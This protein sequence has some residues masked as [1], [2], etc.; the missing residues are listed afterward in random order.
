ME[1]VNILETMTSA[2]KLYK[3]ILG[4]LEIQYH[5]N[6]QNV[7]QEE[8]LMRIDKIDQVMANLIKIANTIEEYHFGKIENINMVYRLGH[9]FIS[10][11][12]ETTTFYRNKYL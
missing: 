8:L 3:Y 9:R 10:R 1:S 11:L 6:Y 5:L 7:S 2:L 12:I 4:E